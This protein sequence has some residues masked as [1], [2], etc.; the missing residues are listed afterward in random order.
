MRWATIAILAAAAAAAA[1][2][3]GQ[4][5]RTTRVLSDG[6][7]FAK[8]AKAPAGGAPE[9]TRVTVP[10]SWNRVGHYTNPGDHPNRPETLDGY[11]G[12]AWYRLEFDAP[13]DPRGKRTF[14]EFDAASRTA[15]VWLNGKRLGSHAGGFSRFRFD[16]TDALKPGAANTLMVRVDNTAPDVGTATADVL[17]LAGDFFVHGG[18]YRPV[19]LIV[20][21]GVHF[22]MLDH[23]GSGVYATTRSIGGGRALIDV[24]W[25]AR[26]DT[27]RPA[28]VG[29]VV[30]LLDASGAVKAEQRRPVTLAGGAGGEASV[31]LDVADPHLWNGVADPY[32]H[33]L[34]VDL[35]GADGRVLDRVEQ[36]FGIREVRVD[37]ARGLFLNGKPLRL[38]GV[39]YHQ[40]REGK[41]WAVSDA[42]IAE[43]VAI[44]RE[45]GANT[46]RLT[47]YQHGQPIH[48]LADRYGL[49]VWDEIPLVSRW[50]M[51]AATTASDGLRENAAQQ[52]RELIRQNGNH[53]SVIAW[54][55]ANEVDFGK[56]IPI[57]ITN[58][59]GPAPDPMPLLAELN[60]IAKAEDPSRPT[61]IAT[62]CEG[63][64]LG[65]AE[66][67]ITAGAADVSG[68]NRYFGWYYGEPAGLG[69]H[70]DA[71]RAARPNQ[72]LSV[73]EYGAGGATSIHTDN[74]LGGDVDQRGRNQPEEYESY[75]HETAWATLS[76]KP[77]LWATWL[78][79]S[80]DFATTRRREGDAIDINTKGLVT[81]DRAIRKDAY[82]FYKANWSA[83]PTVHINGRR[84]VDRAYPF[85]DVRVYSN[86][87]ETELV[88]GGKSLGTMKDCPQRICVWPK[89][90]LATG[91]NAVIARGR[92]AGGVTEDRLEWRLSP[93]A[94]GTIR[95]DSGALVAG[96]R[97]FGSD[98][99]FDGGEA[100][101]V[102]AS[103]GYGKPPPP[104]VVT[105]TDAALVAQTYR[106]GDFAYR[107]PLPR[108][109]YTVTLTFAE[110]SLNAGER[111]FD[112]TANGR[113]VVA[114]LDVAKEAG[115]A[116]KAV[117]RRFPVQVGNAGL[118][119]RFAGRT[120]KAIVS[121]IE[122]GR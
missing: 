109:R 68:A 85:T 35:V 55:I 25:R 33:R 98:D 67:P 24:R 90:A 57:F 50:T 110:P 96:A 27:A 41:G 84:Y 15:E 52:M 106:E 46:I 4:D 18:L 23:G 88:I 42:D 45:M 95:I 78:W 53:A 65:D 39:G 80:F 72:P 89:V 108:G 91:S 8:G 60:A 77:Y 115:G 9:W 38:H 61:A 62:C 102:N 32:L 83:A 116:L 21:D 2:A 51:G 99:F 103:T 1:P 121:A 111:R 5:V 11:Q 66:V 40:D 63:R 76:S 71:L 30:R 22:D 114:G 28:R 36:S 44:M 74:A 17:P 56:S 107:V 13:R 87:P 47:H 73:T 6:W 69:P 86:A 48:D 97:D 14:L 10:H 104:K 112:V 117:T 20:T 34:S 75:I 43:D 64:L 7:V 113:R 79:N 58:K 120:G 105:G 19:R 54:G 100:G 29:A 59:D 31:T 118:E 37:P 16:A 101:D 92:F 3:A 81:Y 49:L 93:E 119:L 26:N 12:V 94:A 70:L 82:Y 122:V